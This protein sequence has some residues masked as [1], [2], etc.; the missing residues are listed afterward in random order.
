M[1]DVLCL[2]DGHAVARHDHDFPGAGQQRCRF[3]RVD[4]HDFAV[5]RTSA[6]SGA[7]AGAE[8]AGY[9][10]EELAVHRPAHDVAEDCTAGTD[11]CTGDDQQVV[12]EHEARGR[13]RPARVAVEHGHDNRHVGAAYG[14]YHVD[15]KQQ[16]KHGHDD[17]RHDTAAGRRLDHERVAVPDRSEQEQQVEPVACRQQHRASAD[18]AR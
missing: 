14:H 12:V 15:T 5:L 3:L 6:R 13:C 18:A 9:D 11:Q 1:H 10:V 4:R 2:R 8:A 16:R 17:E 7:A